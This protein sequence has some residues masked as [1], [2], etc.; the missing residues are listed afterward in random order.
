ML[1]PPPKTLPASRELVLLLHGTLG[2][3]CL[4]PPAQAA[5]TLLPGPG[6]GPAAGSGGW[7]SSSQEDSQLRWYPL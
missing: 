7:G 5:H 4:N 2:T 6:H 1:E 3:P